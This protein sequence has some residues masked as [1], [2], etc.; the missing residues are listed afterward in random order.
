MYESEMV[1]MGRVF[2]GVGAMVVFFF[3]AYLIYHIARLFKYSGDY[4]ERITTFEIA[5]LDKIAKAKG[6][7]LRKEIEQNRLLVNRSFRRKIR[8]EMYT[9]MFCKDKE[10]KEDK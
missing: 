5:V 10:E 9:E 3:I 4:E 6:I 7:D 8:D 1:D 2:I